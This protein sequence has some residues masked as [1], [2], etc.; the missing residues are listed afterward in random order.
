MRSSFTGSFFDL[1]NPFSLLCGI[2]SASMLTM[3]GAVW[4]K[5]RSGDPIRQRAS[6]VARYA[7]MR[8]PMD[9]LTR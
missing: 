9:R 6:I 1:L 5:M 7:V 8:T 4:Q 2:V 3:Q